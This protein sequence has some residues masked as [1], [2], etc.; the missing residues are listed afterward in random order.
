[1]KIGQKVFLAEI[2]ESDKQDS[3]LVREYE[4]KLLGKK[5][6]E[7]VGPRHRL[8]QTWLGNMGTIHLLGSD[9][10]EAVNNLEGLLDRRLEQARASLRRHEE[11]IAAKR[12]VF[13]R[14]HAARNCPN[15]K[16]EPETGFPC[17]SCGRRKTE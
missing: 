11:D 9:A 14:W 7:L 6:Y 5:F 12:K 13:Y 4:V 3:I 15:C 1:M 2:V 8:R 17:V 16:G 10:L